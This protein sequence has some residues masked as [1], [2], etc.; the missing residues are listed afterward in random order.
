MATKRDFYEVLGVGKSASADEIKKSYR[1]L[2]RKYHP[3]T[4]RNDPTA[5]GKF[6]EVQE[7]YDVLSD[8]KKREAYDQF[9]HAGVNSAHAA[10]AAAAAAAA[11]RGSGGFRYQTQTPGGATVD[12]GE[13][14]LNDILESMMGGGS[15]RGKARG[16]GGGRGNPFGFGQEPEAPPAAGENIHYPLTISFEEAIQGKSTDV[17][18]TTPNGTIDELISVKIP[19]GVNEGSKVAARGKGQPGRNGG[20]RGDLIIVIHVEPHAYFRRDGNDIELDLPVSPAEAAAGATISVPT[21]DGP[22]EIRIPP[23]IGSGKRLRIRER[24]VKLKD[25]SRGDQ[26]CRILVQVPADLSEAEKAQLAAMEKAHGFNARR[27]AKWQ[28]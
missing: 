8:A 20:P 19:P 16:G 22:V 7:A 15:R 26:Y 25:G 6:K 1:K 3:D 9:G 4:N 17:R 5:E 14:D 10:E 18:L 28:S 13:V 2:A 21:I 11:G 12:F 27:D 23:G 24:G